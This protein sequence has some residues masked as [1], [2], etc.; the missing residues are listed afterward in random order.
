MHCKHFINVYV[1]YQIVFR[2]MFYLGDCDAIW[3]I[4]S[5]INFLPNDVS[6]FH[7]TWIMSLHYLVTLK[8]LIG[9]VLPLSCESNKLQN[10]F[11]LNC[12]LQIRQNW[13]QLITECGIIAKVFK[14]L[15]TDLDEL[16]QRLR[17]EW[18]A[19]GSC[20]HCRSHSSVASSVGPDQWLSTPSLAIFAHAVIN[21]IQIWQIW[22]PQLRW[23]KF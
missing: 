15:I 22:T 9:H 23:D 11:H 12:G 2:N 8:M 19:A 16:K 3:Y 4:V 5:Q 17:T 20:S 1:C 13:I 18:P 10:L 14:I 7:L 6:V 21:W